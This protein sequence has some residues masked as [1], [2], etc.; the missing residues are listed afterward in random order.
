[1]ATVTDD[2]LGL[3]IRD[4]RKAKGLTQ[5]ALAHKIGYS[6]DD[7][8]AYISRLE[9]GQQEPQVRTLRRIA[10]ALGVAMGTLLRTRK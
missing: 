7:A 10:D 1:M 6:G 9:N 5:L 4:A 3:N 2:S 8:G